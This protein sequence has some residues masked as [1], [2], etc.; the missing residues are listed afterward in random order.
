MIFLGIDL[1]SNCFTC[2]FICQDGT[3]KS[4]SFNFSEYSLKQFYSLLTSETYVI[5]EASTNTFKFV[6][7]LFLKYFKC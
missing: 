3:K 6:E 7:K 2:C 4:L 5:V 1:H